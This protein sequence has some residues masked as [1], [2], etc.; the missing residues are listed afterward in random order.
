MWEISVLESVFNEIAGINSRFA[1]LVKKK[2]F[3]ED[4]YF[5]YI[6]T[7]IE[8]SYISSNFS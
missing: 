4:I 8:M 6:R 5:E 3:T 7:L 2:T 1:S